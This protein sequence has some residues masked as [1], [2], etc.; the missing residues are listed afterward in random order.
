MP[1]PL[2]HLYQLQKTAE[3][4]SVLAFVAPVFR[5]FCVP[6]LCVG[7]TGTAPIRLAQR[8]FATAKYTKTPQVVANLFES[9]AT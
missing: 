1:C 5:D 3:S 4:V 7:K 8:R 6:T 9:V 2:T